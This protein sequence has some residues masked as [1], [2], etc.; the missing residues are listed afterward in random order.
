MSIVENPC[1]YVNII[2]EKKK[3]SPLQTDFHC[4]A[5]R[6]NKNTSAGFDNED[7]LLRD[8]LTYMSNHSGWF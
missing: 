7:R 8:C 5:A 3:M 1:C 6:A 4:V 2:T